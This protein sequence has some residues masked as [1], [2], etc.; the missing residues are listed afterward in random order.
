MWIK[1]EEELFEEIYQ[2]WE[3]FDFEQP[4]YEKLEDLQGFCKK[5]RQEILIYFANGKKLEDILCL[6][7]YKKEY[8][9]QKKSK[10]L[11]V[12]NNLFD[13]NLLLKRTESGQPFKEIKAF[14]GNY[15][16]RVPF[17]CA[18]NKCKVEKQ[19]LLFQKINIMNQELNS[20][21]SKKAAE[22]KNKLKDK[23]SEA[24]END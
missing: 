6:S 8:K 10:R 17:Y 7:C 20:C 21:D 9:N 22:F 5:C 24:E 14:C 2:E 19:S 15:V 13:L 11:Y 18:Q 12:R 4:Q 3:D 23:W 16:G 1:K